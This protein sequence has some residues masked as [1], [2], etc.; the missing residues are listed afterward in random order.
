MLGE[1]G[2]GKSSITLRFVRDQFVE[3]AQSTIGA[4]FVT[5]NV[6]SNGHMVIYGDDLFFAR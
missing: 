6:V 1:T 5:K 3:D 4:A 2:V